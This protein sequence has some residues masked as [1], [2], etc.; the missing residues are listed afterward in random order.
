MIKKVFIFL[1]TIIISC[2][3]N[4][5]D[6]VIVTQKKLGQPIKLMLLKKDA[7]SSS[8]YLCF[9]KTISFHND[10]KQKVRIQ[11]IHI[12]Y[13]PRGQST[14]QRIF[15]FEDQIIRNPIPKSSLS[16]NE[17]KS[18]N[19][20]YSYF[21]KINNSTINTWIKNNKVIQ[22]YQDR[23]IYNINADSININ[24]LK[25]KID[26]EYKGKLQIEFRDKVGGFRI[27]QNITL[28]E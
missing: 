27:S 24:W 12:Y 5:S 25:N 1:F 2:S 21:L 16:V 26:E 17:K 11:D 15:G 18:Y 6:K 8:V 4:I 23:L 3:S 20:Y 7:D 22:K 28:L 13:F 14:R 19:V 10:T 9:S